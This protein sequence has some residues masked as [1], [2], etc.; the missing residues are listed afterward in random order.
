MS[1]EGMGIHLVPWRPALE[2][3]GKQMSGVVSP[4]GGEDWYFGRRRGFAIRIPL[5]AHPE[6]L[7]NGSR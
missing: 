4:G 1:D 3:F 7:K 2:Q 6:L 5:R